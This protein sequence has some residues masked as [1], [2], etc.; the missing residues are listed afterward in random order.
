MSQPAKRR[1]SATRFAY[2]DFDGSK[3]A[4]GGSYRTIRRQAALRKKINAGKCP[5]P[6]VA[7]T[8]RCQCGCGVVRVWIANK[9]PKVV[10]K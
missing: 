1:K 9:M 4:S 2:I 3:L 6:S 10:V 8:A 7:M 5:H